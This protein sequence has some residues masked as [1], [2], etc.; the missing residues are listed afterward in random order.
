GSAVWVRL[1]MRP[2]RDATGRVEATRSTLTDV[3]AL[4]RAEDALRASEERLARVL[5]SA[6]DAN[7]T[8]DT[9]RRIAIFNDA[10]ETIFHCRPAAVLG[11]PPDRFLTAA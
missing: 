9:T 5:A 3:T 8:I 4:K 10:A 2:I 6:M 7:V 11:Q 1:S